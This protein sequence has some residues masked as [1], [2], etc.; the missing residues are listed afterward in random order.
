MEPAPAYTMDQPGKPFP[1]LAPSLLV[2]MPQLNDPNFQRS[3]ILLCEHG[4]QGAFGLVL[5]RRTDTPA[6][7]VVRLTPPVSAASRLELWIGGPVEPERGWILMGAEPTDVESVRVCDGIFLS[8]SPRLLRRLLESPPPP[9]T[10]LLTGYAGWGAGQLDAELA[11]SSWL[12]ADID[13][14][15]V[16]DTRPTDMWETT[17]RSMGADPSFLQQGGTGAVH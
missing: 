10:R 1:S 16:F 5:N 8:T 11:A 9:R 7:E 17:I 4:P 12:H 3:V 13:L 15:I 2:S 14:D 6:A